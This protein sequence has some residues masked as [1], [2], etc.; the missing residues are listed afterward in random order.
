MKN[1]NPMTRFKPGDT[2][3]VVDTYSGLIKGD[4][5][6]VESVRPDSSYIKL[7]GSSMFF[8]SDYFKLIRSGAGQ[9]DN[10]LK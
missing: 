6:I 5:W 10:D 3:E 2:V 9:I 1:T 8:H 7:K 4:T